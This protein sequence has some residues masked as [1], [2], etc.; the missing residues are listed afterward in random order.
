VPLLS[1]RGLTRRPWFSG[2]ALDLEEGEIVV[3]AGRTGSGKTL[4]LRTLADLDPSEEGE[5]F[6]RDTERGSMP[7]SEW[8]RQV[9]YVHQS[10]VTLPGTVRR[11]VERLTSLGGREHTGEPMPMPPGLPGEA[12]AGRLSGGERQILALH[13]ALLCEPSVLLLDEC[14]SALDPEAAAYW[15]ERLRTWADD[16]Y[17]ALWVAHD[18]TLGARLRAR[19]ERLS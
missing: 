5:V 11:N 19:T 10:G 14:T 1:C 7:A 18:K 15:E 13:C 8:R 3:L 6:L 16:G 17:A 2:R 9:L 4:F 12:D